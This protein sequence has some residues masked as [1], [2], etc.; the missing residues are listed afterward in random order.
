[1]ENNFTK[2]KRAKNQEYADYLRT[3]IQENKLFQVI[4]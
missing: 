3:C 1:M 2:M 4:L